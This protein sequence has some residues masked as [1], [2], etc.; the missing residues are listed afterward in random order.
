MNHSTILIE[1]DK[2]EIKPVADLPGIMCDLINDISLVCSIIVC[3]LLLIF[4]EVNSKLNKET[5]KSVM[6]RS[7]AFEDTKILQ[8]TKPEPRAQALSILRGEQ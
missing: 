3:H 5:V 6:S 1:N 7:S 4:H 2:L 8:T